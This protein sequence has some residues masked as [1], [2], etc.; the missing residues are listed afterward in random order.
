[1]FIQPRLIQEMIG[2]G[3]PDGIDTTSLRAVFTGGYAINAAKLLQFRKLVPQT[4]VTQGYGLSEVAGG[5]TFF[6][7]GKEKD[8]LLSW[9]KSESCGRPIKGLL[10]KVQIKH[11]VV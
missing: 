8:V 4:H 7:G 6:N 9:K 10:Y 1:M 3:R 11:V 5:V 2:T